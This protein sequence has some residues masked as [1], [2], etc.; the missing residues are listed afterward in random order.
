MGDVTVLRFATPTL[1]GRDAIAQRLQALTELLESTRP[2]WRQR[3]YASLP[4]PWEREHDA[5]ADWLRALPRER[6]EALHL[7]PAGLREAP[8][9]LPDLIA[10]ISRLTSV[11]ALPAAPLAELPDPV[12]RLN[13]R[14]REQVAAL[15]ATA[16]VTLPEGT[17]VLVDWCCGKGHLGRTLSAARDLP[18]IGLERNAALCRTGGELA[19]STTARCVFVPMDVLDTARWPAV[20]AL[21]TAV[22]ALH[23]CGALTDAALR[24][25]LDGHARAVL[26]APCCYHFVAAPFVCRSAEGRASG[27]V[28]EAA[29]LRL[30]TLEEV[31]AP[32]AIR[33]RRRRELAWRLGL[34]VLLLEGG[35]NR[36]PGVAPRGSLDGDFSAF[37][38][39]MAA[40]HELK[41]PATW[42]PARTEADGQAREGLVAALSLVRSQFRRPLELWLVL[43]RALQLV[44]SGWNATVGTFCAREITP[45]NLAIAATHPALREGSPLPS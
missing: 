24:F 26:I 45:R 10:A 40:A 1:S 8:G 7:E 16:T 4:L 17:E 21:K 27:F 22:V 37:V 5:L 19:A 12:T 34:D 23:A 35:E 18:C 39:A 2:F 30:P 41:L 14:K 36:R 42:N 44:E 25:A 33:R 6:V 29:D 31:I 20:P 28:L 43:D 32:P 9:P 15:V 3:P 11:G 13:G 38:Q